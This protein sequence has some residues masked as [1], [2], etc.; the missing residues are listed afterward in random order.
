M[1]DHI[2]ISVSNLEKSKAFYAAALNPLGIAIKMEFEGEVV[3]FGK[4]RPM[5]WVSE[6]KPGQT[7]VAFAAANKDVVDAFYAEA[8]HAGG[9][10]NGKP[11]YQ[12]D[13][14]PGYYAAF[15]YDLDGNNIEAVFH[16]PSLIK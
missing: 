3:G 16:D 5:F 4:E 1:F 9:K 10:D 14:S 8:I 2:G 15:A 13:Y 12:K 11:E 6:G 7:H